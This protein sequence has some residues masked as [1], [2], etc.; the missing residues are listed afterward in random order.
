MI[1]NWNNGQ[2]LQALTQ[3]QREQNA[4][5]IWG[6]FQQRGWT[7]EAVSGMLGNIHYES[8]INPAQWQTGHTIEDP[9]YPNDTGFGLVQWTPWQNYANW[10]TDAGYNWRTDYTAQLRRIQ[11]EL[12]NGEQWIPVSGYG[13]MTFE[14]FTQST[15]TPEYLAEVFEYSYERGTWAADRSTYARQWYDY[16]GGAGPLFDRLPIWLL[17]KLRR[18]NFYG[19]SAAL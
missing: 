6:F 18:R 16:L 14:Q 13:S 3:E 7:L 19:Y 12:D 9:A 11:W 5:E 15:Q 10:A 1:G 2:A 8:G 17:F 4:R